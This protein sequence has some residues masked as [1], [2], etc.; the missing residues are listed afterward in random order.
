MA[1]HARITLD[2]QR[3]I[4]EIHPRLYG[5]F[6]EHL[7]RAVY[8]GVYEPDHPAADAE[9]F[10]QD[11]LTLIRELH[12][13]IVRYPGG[14][15]VSGYDWEDGI[16]PKSQRP[17]R[18]ELAWRAIETNQFGTDDF[19]AW[20]RQA[21]IEPML[22]VNLGSRGLDA[23]RHMLEYCNHPG[24][25]YWSD[26]RRA[27]GA[28]QPHNVKVWCLGNELDGPWQIGHK[29]AS[30]YGRLAEETAKV[31]KQVDS[32]VELVVCGSSFLS[33]P[34]F[35]A[36]EATVL[37]H[38]YEYVDYLSLHTYYGSRTAPPRRYLA[39]SLGMDYFIN[40]TVSI[41]DATK[42]RKRSKKTMNLSFDEWNVWFQGDEAGP[43][44]EPWQVGPPHGEGTYSVAD[45]L[46]FGC[47]LI[48]LLR[49]AD[50]IKIGCQ[51][52]LVNVIAPI[53]TQNGGPSWRQTIY[54][55][56]QH[57]A[58]Y[59]HGVALDLDLQ[60]AVYADE[61]FDAVPYIESVATYDATER[62]L[63]IFAVNRNP[64]APIQ[65]DGDVRAF[66]G[67]RVVEHIILS[68]PNLNATNTIEHPDVVSPRA[69][70]NA[71]LEQGQLV[72]TLPAVSWNVI[73]L[74][75]GEA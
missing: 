5:S 4:G 72:A 29:T 69:D 68:H 43:K 63:T 49:H 45:A 2:P 71:R 20:C 70:G 33:M 51:A 12:T 16:G 22:T 50:R 52:I 73:R 37:D 31:M 25:T 15:F 75:A 7:G 54:Y 61:E 1:D 66:A 67:Y 17:R 13:P 32:S 6:L 30:E 65:L 56:F 23:A 55:P 10:R 39:Q 11:V 42:A 53:M 41:C 21:N 27:N 19:I 38:T 3:K 48:T 26:L 46:L 58:R 74:S 64:D 60:C 59:G 14:N 35:G 24:G 9:G 62:N 18:L 36:W 34:T 8:G 28:S 57:A 44:A 47:M 40:A